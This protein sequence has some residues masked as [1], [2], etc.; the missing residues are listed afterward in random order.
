MHA[1]TGDFI[2]LGKGKSSES[3][4]GVARRPSS[5]Q[6][7][8]RKLA[9]GNERKRE[10]AATTGSTLLTKKPK[11]MSQTFTPLGR[12]ASEPEKKSSPSTVTPLAF[13]ESAIEGVV[14]LGFGIGE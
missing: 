1:P 13:E 3:D 2:A 14:L 12:H 4:I 8:S 7:V 10:A 9:A 11:L 6:P 5:P